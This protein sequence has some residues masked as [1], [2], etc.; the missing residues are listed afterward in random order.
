MRLI[1]T[2]MLPC[3]ATGGQPTAPS[4]LF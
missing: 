1:L 4:F 2:R 3:E